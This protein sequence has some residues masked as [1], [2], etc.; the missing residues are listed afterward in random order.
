MRG[1]ESGGHVV[2]CCCGLGRVATTTHQA[3]GR[4]HHVGCCVACAPLRAPS[5]QVW[6]RAH[7]FCSPARPC[8]LPDHSAKSPAQ[9]ACWPAHPCQVREGTTRRVTS[10]RAASLPAP[11]CWPCPPSH[12]HSCF[13]P[14]RHARARPF[15][16][17]GPPPAAHSASQRAASQRFCSTSTGSGMDWAPPGRT[18]APARLSR[19]LPARDL[20]GRGRPRQPRSA[21]LVVHA[22]SEG[23]RAGGWWC[24]HGR[25]V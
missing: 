18:G 6:P 4:E 19:A 9:P 23:E 11:S 1:N 17:A 3:P 12:R 20:W 10:A 21:A 2:H 16:R 15:A 7:S 14:C 22:M 5:R 13:R 8:C 24:S 25:G